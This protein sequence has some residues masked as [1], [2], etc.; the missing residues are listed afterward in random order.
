MLLASADIPSSASTH[1]HFLLLPSSSFT[2]LIKPVALSEL[3]LPVEILPAE[4]KPSQEAQQTITHCLEQVPHTI[5][6]L[7]PLTLFT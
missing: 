3:L 6:F 2:L 4:E 7:L 1:P 5:K